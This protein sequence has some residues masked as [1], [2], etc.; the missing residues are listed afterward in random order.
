MTVFMTLASRGEPPRT[1]I[2]DQVQ[3]F[4]TA[5]SHCQA[6][7]V[8]DNSARGGQVLFIMR[9]LMSCSQLCSLGFVI[10]LYPRVS[11]H[12]GFISFVP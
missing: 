10:F 3:Y 11:L 12:S 4:A 1:Y 5:N 9:F 7:H 2:L 6:Q 8:D